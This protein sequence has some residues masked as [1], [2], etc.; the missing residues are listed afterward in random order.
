MYFNK[1]MKAV[2]CE[3]PFSISI[4]D[5]EV[6]KIKEKEVLV[7]VKTAGVFFT[8]LKVYTGLF[9]GVEYPVILG[10]E[11]SGEI[12]A[13]GKNVNDLRIGDEVIVE[14]LFPCGK[15]YLCLDGK[16]NMCID[17]KILGVNKDGTF[18]E[19]VVAESSRVHLKDKLLSHEQAILINDLAVA[20]HAIKRSG[21]SIGDTAVILG[22]DAIGLLTLQVAKRSGA[23]VLIIDTNPEKLHLAADFD[24]DYVLSPE[25]G[26]I[27]ELVMAMTKDKGADVVIDCLG[28][29]Q[30]IKQTVDLV[31]KGGKIIMVGWTG[32]ETDPMNLTKMV[33]NE[34]NLLGCIN[35]C[36]EFQ[37]A[38]ELANS[39]SLNLNSI[40]SHSFDFYQIPKVFGSLL[41]D[42]DIVKV[43]INFVE[44]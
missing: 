44:L 7:K 12:S 20:I 37:I 25:A 1:I 35:Y 38:M 23:S 29:S 43:I 10:H 27:Q 5:V 19:Y 18:A 6:P 24:A 22:A 9:P 11:L 2:L 42:K 8:D 30:T 21:I 32:N 17:S 15:C 34:I 3:K 14:P 36:G 26:N 40:I 41:S 13:L 16:H 33:M 31:K 28:T 39:G 4:K